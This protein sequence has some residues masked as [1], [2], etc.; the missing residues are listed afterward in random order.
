MCGATQYRRRQRQNPRDEIYKHFDFVDFTRPDLRL[1]LWPIA[2]T[3]RQLPLRTQL[4]GL[5][6]GSDW[7][8][9]PLLGKLAGRQANIQMPSLGW[10]G[11]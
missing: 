7:R 9:W 11:V 4:F 3:W 8:S 5:R 1:P 2:S 10:R 6:P